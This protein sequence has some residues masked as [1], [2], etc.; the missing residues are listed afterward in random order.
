MKAQRSPEDEIT[1]SKPTKILL[2]MAKKDEEWAGVAIRFDTQER[3]R[4]RNLDELRRWLKS[5]YTRRRGE[6]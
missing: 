4:F 6:T 1:R 5:L 3:H 2:H